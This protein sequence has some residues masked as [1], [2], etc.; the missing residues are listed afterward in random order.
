MTDATPTPDP[1]AAPA[2]P[3]YAAAPAAG[4]K[5]TLS[6]VGFILGICSVVFAW[7]FFL[8]LGAGIAAIIVS[9]KAR[10]DEPAAPKWMP[11]VG[12]ITGIVGIILSVLLG[13]VYLASF[14][15]PLLILGSYGSVVSNY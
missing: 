5:Q 14:I 15:I 8:G 3:A 2:A 1:A 6:I 4:P 13:I 12:I 10:K 11:Q 7:T 9:R